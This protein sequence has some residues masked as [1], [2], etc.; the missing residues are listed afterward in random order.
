MQ[1]NIGI[2]SKRSI[3]DR[4]FDIDRDGFGSGDIGYGR[5]TL[6]AAYGRRRRDDTNRVPVVIIDYIVNNAVDSG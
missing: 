2:A 1:G 6:G 5:L 3:G 4:R